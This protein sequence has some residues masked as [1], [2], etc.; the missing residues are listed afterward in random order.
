MDVSFKHEASDKTTTAIVDAAGAV[1]DQMLSGEKNKKN[2]TGVTELALGTLSVTIHEE[3]DARDE[4]D[5]AIE[6]ARAALEV[7]STMRVTEEKLRK[8]LAESQNAFHKERSE[9]TSERIEHA[10]EIAGLKNQLEI[11]KDECKRLLA[12][13]KKL[14]DL[15]RA[16][17]ASKRKPS[18]RR[19]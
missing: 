6:A 5:K 12:D 11:Y 14:H 1:A 9:F 16:K 8:K 15:Y 19:S 3:Q 7:A 17:K 18:K 13:N 10:K 4:R 2:G